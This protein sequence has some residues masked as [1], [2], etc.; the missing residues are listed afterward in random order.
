MGFC[1]DKHMKKK[2]IDEQIDDFE[3]ALTIDLEADM[4]DNNKDIVLPEHRAAN[5]DEIASSFRQRKNKKPFL[6]TPYISFWLP[7]TISL[8]W[9]AF[10]AWVVANS[11]P[12]QL[13]EIAI[14]NWR[15]PDTL[16]IVA[17]F[18]VPI[19][20]VWV[21]A[22]N[23][24]KTRE[25]NFAAREISQVAEQ[26]K[27][28]ETGSIDAVRTTGQAVRIE[29]ETLNHEMQE[30]L[31]LAKQLESV[32]T[33]EMTGLKKNYNESQTQIKQL[34]DK[35]G[36]ERE[37]VVQEGK[38][39]EQ[40]VHN[41]SDTLQQTMQET[42]Q[43]I[44][45]NVAAMQSDFATALTKPN[46]EIRTSLNVAEENLGSVLSAK[47]HE[48]S[49]RMNNASDEISN[50]IDLA[51]E[52][53]NVD[54]EGK[55][56][57]IAETVNKLEVSL[58]KHTQDISDTFADNL[59]KNRKDIQ[60]DLDKQ[61]ERTAE[62]IEN[63]TIDLSLAFSTKAEEINQIVDNQIGQIENMF[64]NSQTKINDEFSNKTT[65]IKEIIQEQTNELGNTMGEQLNNYRDAIKQESEKIGQEISEK[66]SQLENHVMSS[67]LSMETQV[68]MTLEHIDKNIG[69]RT[70]EVSDSL[71]QQ[72]EKLHTLISQDA[73]PLLQD[74][75]TRGAIVSDMMAEK[76]KDASDQAAN[77]LQN[78]LI[79]SH[80]K[81]EQ[82]TIDASDKL[83]QEY[84][85]F[86][87]NFANKT[88]HLVEQS[89]NE[90]TALN[91]LLDRLEESNIALATLVGTSNESLESANK[92]FNEKT[93]EFSES[94][95]DIS[96]NLGHAS[97]E[98]NANY[99]GMKE[100][101]ENV[102]E[103]IINLNSHFSSQSKGLNDVLKFL[104][105]TQNNMEISFTDKKQAIEALTQNLAQKSVELETLLN[106]F[107]NVLADSIANA[108]GQAKNL[109]A[110]LAQSVSNA[111]NEATQKFADA[112][113][114]MKNIANEVQHDLSK[115]RSE[116]KKSVVDLPQETRQSTDA[117]RKAVT[118]QIKALQDLNTIVK[119]ATK[120]HNLNTLNSSADS[121]IDSQV[122]SQVPNNQSSENF[123]FD[124]L[125]NFNKPNNQTQQT[126]AVMEKP[127]T[128]QTPAS[129]LA[130]QQSWVSDLLNRA[131][132]H[133]NENIISFDSLL[134][135]M[136]SAIDTQ[137]ISQLWQRYQNGEKN[138]FTQN[139]YNGE[140]QNTF[141]Q[142]KQKYATD[143]IFKQAV[144]KFMQDFEN[145]LQ[146]TAQDNQKLLAQLVSDNGKIYTMLAHIVGRFGE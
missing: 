34:V 75:E 41:I 141:L 98:M 69:Q 56:I 116:L 24:R 142:V 33:N 66:T 105:E 40:A 31:N 133:E 86:E 80:G 48:I 32:L 127:Q 122:N 16:Y 78:H 130:P 134:P 71:A 62:I 126:Q 38:E 45:D 9:I 93:K 72:T 47:S 129:P 59:E 8:I 18:I 46:E 117:M 103:K 64:D 110:G 57:E 89:Q 90:L 13:N 54:I 7:T 131:S 104:N 101:S 111:A 37:K 44:A 88:K 119:N 132:Q 123:N 68:D 146:N 1:L 50:I 11:F 36:T 99:F 84:E 15:H 145:N 77:A 113:H 6:N 91:G 136:A 120:Y 143:D 5:D 106:R 107:T 74:F 81:M 140:G 52:K 22:F 27:Q 25:L 100:T 137:H 61:V 94:M 55:K 67:V 65:K 23:M 30:S 128:Q 19:I 87:Q 108:E 112:T 17:G 144:V 83:K 4:Q 85:N 135:K 124:E 76:V 73:I 53:A 10:S 96:E 42:K 138:I 102:L 79:E 51:N 82:I 12:Q 125:K 114:S 97:R 115:T 139:M 3:K 58:A 92:M 14:E 95:S 28:P 35:L 70:R 26:L 118:D 39:I 60:V 109:T 2:S 29:M 21:I 20:M 43:G 49:E 63:K 121:P